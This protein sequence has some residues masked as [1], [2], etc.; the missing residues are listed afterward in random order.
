MRASL[1]VAGLLVVCSAGSLLGQRGGGGGGPQNPFLGNTQAIAEG[2]ALYHKTC[3]TC[4]GAN[5]GGGEIG[6]AIVAGDRMDVGVSDAQTFNV[7]KNGV[8]GTP[9]RPQGLPDSDIWKIV[10]YIHSLRG[11]AID[12]P[13]PGDIAHGE[14]VFFGKGQCSSCHMLGGK[15][16][17]TAPD[18]SN[19][20]GRRKSSSIVDAL[21]KEQHRV[22]GS[23]GAHLSS[24]PTMDSYLPVHI[25]TADGKTVD[26]ILLNED[27]Y[28][29]QMIG[30]DNQLH[31][32]DRAKLRRVVV[33][34]KSLMPTDYDKRLSSDEFKDLMA[35]LTRQGYK[36]PASAGRGG[37][38]PVE[39]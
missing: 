30:S 38:P 16:G 10:A 26:G 4:H 28:S 39:Q 3:T 21:T 7:I 27:G 23:G 33:E 22:Y 18:L 32:F 8:Q 15:G 13:L 6:P 2:D 12:N 20:A 31:L 19:I 9:M 25:T 37:G 11:T 24:L 17:L 36:A 35:Y 14:A 29:I 5:G 1:F 34:P